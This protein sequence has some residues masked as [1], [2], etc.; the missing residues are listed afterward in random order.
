MLETRLEQA[1]IYILTLLITPLYHSDTDPI[2]YPNTFDY[3]KIYG[4][5]Y[6]F[7][8]FFFCHIFETRLKRELKYPKP[9]DNGQQRYTPK[10]LHKR[11]DHTKNRWESHKAFG[12]CW[13]NTFRNCGG[14]ESFSSPSSAPTPRPRRL[15]EAEPTHASKNSRSNK[16]PNKFCERWTR[17]IL[18][19]QPRRVLLRVTLPVYVIP[20]LSAALLS[21]RHLTSVT[22]SPTPPIT[23]LSLSRIR[24]RVLLPVIPSRRHFHV[25]G[26][27]AS[28]SAHPRSMFSH[29]AS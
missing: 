14:W 12:P 17:K 8:F 25:C 24:R 7:F 27:S 18:L 2:F 29:I 23:S 11:F 6:S 26:S 1:F 16:I 22:C 13:G 9:S 15:R 3:I 4:L 21:Q 28:P 10:I 20:P 19:L 5:F